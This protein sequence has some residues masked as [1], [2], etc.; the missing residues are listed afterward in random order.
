MKKLFAVVLCLAMVLSLAA[1]GKLSSDGHT[2]HFFGHGNACFKEVCRIIGCLPVI[3]D[4]DFA[5][6]IAHFVAV[7]ALEHSFGIFP[8]GDFFF[9]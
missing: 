2:V 3:A 5:L 4:P 9:C 6:E 8:D 1:C 7:F